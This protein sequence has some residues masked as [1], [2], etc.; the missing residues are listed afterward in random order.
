[1]S[2]LDDGPRPTLKE[3]ASRAGVHV[4]TVSRAL[5]QPRRPTKSKTT[6]A[7]REIADSIGYQQDSY[8]SA[9]RTGKARTIG[10]LVPRF[11]DVVHAAIYEGIDQAAVSAGYSTV[12]SI[13]RDQSDLQ[14]TC[15]ATLL[16]R[17]VEGIIVQD[18][19]LGSELTRILKKKQMPYLLAVRTL[20]GELSVSVDDVEGGRLAG[21]HLISCGHKNVAVISG[22]LAVSTGRDRLEGFLL[23]FRRVGIEIAPSNIIE[24]GFSLASGR[25]AADRLLSLAQTP[26]AIFASNDLTAVG[27]MAALR[28]AGLHVGEDVAVVG[29]NDIELA[30]QLPVPLTTIHSPL[31]KIGELSFS[32]LLSRMQGEDVHSIKMSPQLRVR[33]STSLWI[34]R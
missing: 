15:L 28:H 24:A 31:G 27:V 10:V 32:T 29:Y 4:S 20:P 6:I 3:I 22:D 11:T 9:L 12:V 26:T 7:I 33:E 18:A 21:E 19:R 5:K 14:L 2:L 13:S 25:D 23:A 1:M 16:S 17:R 30:A 8:A 34:P